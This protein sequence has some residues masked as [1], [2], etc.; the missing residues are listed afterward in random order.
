MPYVGQTDNQHMRNQWGENQPED[1]GG[2][3]FSRGFMGIEQP[4]FVVPLR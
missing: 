2:G 3:G 1:R 4:K